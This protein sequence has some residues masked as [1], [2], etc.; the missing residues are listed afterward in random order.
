MNMENVHDL[1]CNL[2][3]FYEFFI[4]EFKFVQILNYKNIPN[5]EN[6]SYEKSKNIKIH[7]FICLNI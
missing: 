4:D 1:F 7:V 6:M 3:L 2:F 5:F